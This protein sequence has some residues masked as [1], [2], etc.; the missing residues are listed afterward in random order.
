MLTK[1]VHAGLDEM[2]NIQKRVTESIYA[3]IS[4]IVSYRSQLVS[5][6]KVFILLYSYVKY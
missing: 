1:L 4:A 6:K 2:H 5:G 3:C